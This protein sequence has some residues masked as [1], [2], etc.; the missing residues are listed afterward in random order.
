ML[1]PS[2]TVLMPVYNAERFLQE[3]IDSVLQQTFTDFEFLILDDGST[4]KSIDIIQAYTDPRIRFYQNEKN[5]GISATLNRGIALAT[6]EVIARMDADDLCYPH[7]LQQQWEYLQAH[8]DCALVSSN[9][10]IITETGA[11]VRQDDYKSPYYYYN[12][13]FECWIYHPTITFRKNA[14]QEIGAYTVTYS[15]D[16]ELFWQLS[17]K[18]KI[19]NLPEVLLDYRITSQSLHQ[20]QKKQEYDQAQERQVIRNLQYYTTK[21]LHI[22]PAC[23]ASLRHNFKPMLGSANVGDILDCLQTLDHITAGILEKPNPNRDIQAIQ[24][25]AFFKRRFML[26]SFLRELPT[27]KTLYLIAR[28]GAWWYLKNLI[29]KRLKNKIQAS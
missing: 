9:V 15:E 24:E 11:V 10:R 1:K 21:P 22:S 13:T 25:A 27:H 16:F 6:A 18:Y 7:R 20:V 19:Y 4:D 28:S 12:L 17:R 8:P 29:K 2:I 3:A 26:T 23:L 5:L 14:V